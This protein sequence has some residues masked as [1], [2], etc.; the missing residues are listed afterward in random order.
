MKIKTLAIAVSLAFACA[1]AQANEYVAH[2][3]KDGV[4]IKTLSLTFNASATPGRAYAE[5]TEKHN[6]ISKCVENEAAVTEY[7]DMDFSVNNAVSGEYVTLIGQTDKGVDVSVV[8]ADLTGFAQVKAIKGAC[9]WQQP[10]FR[11]VEHFGNVAI[12]KG[13]SIRITTDDAYS[14][15]LIRK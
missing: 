8:W 9:A 3:K 13:Q 11:F 7:P 5:N 10:K 14:I 15:E 2:F 6:Y 1:A 12:A 4:V